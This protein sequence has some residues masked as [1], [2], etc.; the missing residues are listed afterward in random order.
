MEKIFNNEKYYYIKKYEFKFGIV[1]KFANLYN[2][3]Y[4]TEKNGEFIEI[5]NPIKLKKI[6]NEFYKIE[7]EDI[8]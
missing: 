5:K 6:Q 2:C 4:C 3:K 7:I 1:Y 8:I